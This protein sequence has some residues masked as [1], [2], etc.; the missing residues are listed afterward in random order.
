MASQ[1]D[2]SWEA[3]FIEILRT[4]PIP[5]RACTKVGVSF[6]TVLNRRKSHV[7]FKNDMDDAIAE[8]MGTMEEQ[9][10]AM[11]M[12]AREG[13]GPM[14]R[15][16][17]SRRLPDIYGDKVAEQVADHNAGPPATIVLPAQF[18]AGIPQPRDD[19]DE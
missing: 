7:G 13:D 1:K 17:L 10:W 15:W 16:I 6:Q 11:G 8:G 14:V 18:M 9:G 19:E 2:R 12:G 5:R 3:G 4:L